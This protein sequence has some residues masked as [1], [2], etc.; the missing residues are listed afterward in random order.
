MPDERGGDL[1]RL[2]AER[3]VERRDAVGVGRVDVGA[4][5]D[6]EL[7]GGG[8]GVGGRPVQQGVA[9]GAPVDLIGID[10]TG[11]LVSEASFCVINSLWGICVPVI[12]ISKL[13]Y[14]HIPG[15][16]R[17]PRW[18]WPRPAQW[19]RRRPGAWRGRPSRAGVRPC[20]DP[21]RK[22]QPPFGAAT[23]FK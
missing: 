13:S 6:E 2:A 8:V 17:A 9:T 4:V 11:E 12:L 1:L 10:A 5:R 18:T 23:C 7:D 22:G 3:L 19:S 15:G 14:Y 20:W 21:T 16:R